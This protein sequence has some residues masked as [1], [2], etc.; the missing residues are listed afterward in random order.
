MLASF[1]ILT[2]RTD[3]P[4]LL[5]CLPAS[6]LSTTA[7]ESNPSCAEEREREGG[8]EGNDGYEH[9]SDPE[10]E[11]LITRALHMKISHV[12]SIGHLLSRPTGHLYFELSNKQEL[13]TC[14]LPLTLTVYQRML[15][16]P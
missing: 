16:T 15:H 13:L 7:F 6:P 12:L 8:R 11:L 14:P 10:L 3:R 1:L 9:V 4:R 5:F 2:C